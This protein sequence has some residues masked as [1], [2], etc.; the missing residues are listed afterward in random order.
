MEA[1]NVTNSVLFNG[2]ASL[3]I[4]NANFGRITG[5]QNTPRS[6]QLALKVIF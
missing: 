4:N 1:F 2:P 6:L 5:Q 3:D